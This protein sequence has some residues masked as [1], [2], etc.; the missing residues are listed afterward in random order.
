MLVTTNRYGTGPEQ[1]EVSEDSVFELYPGLTSF[2]AHHR[3]AR[4]MEPDS[5]VEWLQ[6]LGDPDVVFAILDPFLFCPDYAFELS[7]SD[8]AALG[9][10]NANEAAIRTIL[11]LSESAEEITANLFAPLVLNRATRLGR[12]VL[13]QDSGWPLRFPVFEGLRDVSRNDPS[14][15]RVHAA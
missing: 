5:P 15:R 14:P 4:I 1:V 2:E 9:L 7:D 12:Q 6:S 10:R 11:T 13:L 8:I 3:Y